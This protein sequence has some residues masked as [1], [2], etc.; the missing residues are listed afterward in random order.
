[1]RRTADVGGS[2]PDETAKR[3]GSF[4]AAWIV[5]AVV[6]AVL[7]AVVSYAFASRNVEA[8]VRAVAVAVVL[9]GASI[10]VGA[11]AGLLF[12]VPRPYDPKSPE[13]AATGETNDA[14]AERGE[15]R[16]HPFGMNTN[17]GDVSDWLTKML[18]GVGLTQITKFPGAFGS[19]TRTVAEAFGGPTPVSRVFAGSL[20]IFLTIFGFIAGWL[21]SVLRLPSELS[22]AIERRAVEA[23]RQEVESHAE[24]VA[25]LAQVYKREALAAL[26][27]VL[28]AQDVTLQRTDVLGEPD[29]VFDHGGVRWQVGVRYPIVNRARVRQELA[30]LAPGSRLLL[31]GPAISKQARIEVEREPSVEYV[32]WRSGEHDG[33]LRAALDG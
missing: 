22:H 14:A 6:A 21:C 2:E 20:M 18:V 15:P 26:Q 4:P 33:D 30:R 9:A 5:F 27:G 11:L 12:G 10:A 24:E 17:L 16:R 13:T 3:R 32:R 8:G 28:G 7:L 29:A 25:D 19:L 1:M 31:I 23:A